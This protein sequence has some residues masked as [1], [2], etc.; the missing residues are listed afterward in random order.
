MNLKETRPSDWKAATQRKTI[1]ILICSN[2]R[3]QPQLAMRNH[4]IVHSSNLSSTLTLRAFHP[5]PGKYNT[6]LTLF[7][8]V[9]RDAFQVLHT[10]S[11]I[12]MLGHLDHT[13]IAKASRFSRH[14]SV[15]ASPGSVCKKLYHSGG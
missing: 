2:S 14:W 15:L 5:L 6:K 7:I 10:E 8:A 4:W 13:G 9:K 11:C 12:M 3:H 1:G